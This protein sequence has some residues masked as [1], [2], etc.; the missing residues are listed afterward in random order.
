MNFD[1]FIQLQALKRKETISGGSLPDHMLDKVLESDPAA[2]ARQVCAMVSQPL[3]DDLEQKCGALEIS[4]R[5]FVEGALIDAL[6]KASRIMRE[7][8]VFE[9]AE[10][11]SAAE[12]GKA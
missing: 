8:G 11:V 1:Q 7:V 10:D 12:G 3:F 4:K 5:R 9:H 6:D 2:K